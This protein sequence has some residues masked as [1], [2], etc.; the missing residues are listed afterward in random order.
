MADLES[1]A[2]GAF[3]VSVEEVSALA[4]MVT[5][6]RA[7]EEPDGV[8]EAAGPAVSKGD[9]EGWITAV[10]ARA[11]L[12]LGNRSKL[13]DETRK[14]ALTAAA[15]DAVVNGAA[16]YLVAAA[17]P[18]RASLNDPGSYDSILWSRFESALESAAQ[19]LDDWLDA[20]VG[21]GAVGGVEIG[22]AFP[23]TSFPDGMRF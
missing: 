5:I 15:H 23:E 10:S 6:G 13:T 20:G 16:S 9:V 2:L 7:E 18:T 14:S 22:G 8:F 11:D 3:G 4:P 19:S 17:M 12:R 1:A 21:G